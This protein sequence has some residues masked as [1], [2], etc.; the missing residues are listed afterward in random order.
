M[1]NAETTPSQPLS[2]LTFADRVACQTA[3]EE[4]YWQNRIWPVENPGAKPPL[5]A[6]L[7]ASTIEQKVRNSLAQSQALADHWQQPITSA[8]LQAEMAR[9]ASQT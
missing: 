4:V 2:P 7:P 6:V 8:M 1:G 9:Q 5:S 3:I